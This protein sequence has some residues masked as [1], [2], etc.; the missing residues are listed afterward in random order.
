[1]IFHFIVHTASF[2]FLGPPAFAAPSCCGSRGVEER[3]S[4]RRTIGSYGDATNCIRASSVVGQHLLRYECCA[5]AEDAASGG[6]AAA[7]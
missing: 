4:K 7:E 6:D 1:M 5:D 2:T 3:L